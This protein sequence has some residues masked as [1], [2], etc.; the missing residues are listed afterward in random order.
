MEASI[1]TTDP[2]IDF[3]TSVQSDKAVLLFTIY[4]RI[5]CVTN[6]QRDKAVR[7]MAVLFSTNCHSVDIFQV[8]S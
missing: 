4:L 8:V 2:R 6:F 1:L 7:D 5:D 3:I